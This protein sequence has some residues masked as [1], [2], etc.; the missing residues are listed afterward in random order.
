[1]HKPS[2]PVENLFRQHVRM[3]G[4]KGVEPPVIRQRLAEPRRGLVNRRALRC[5]D[6]LQLLPRQGVIL[7][8][9]T[10]PTR[11][12]GNGRVFNRASLTA[13]RACDASALLPR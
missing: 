11:Y 8:V 12:T 5:E 6:L 3:S 7:F 2:R 13:V 10:P 4:A 9:S 1:M